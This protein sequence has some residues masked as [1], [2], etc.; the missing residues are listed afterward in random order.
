M[1]RDY[2]ELVC[3]IRTAVRERF[4]DPNQGAFRSYLE[5][6]HVC[7]LGNAF[8]IISGSAEDVKEQI[9]EK[10]AGEVWQKS[11]LAMRGFVYDAL[12]EIGLKEGDMIR[13]GDYELQYYE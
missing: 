10:L 1:E 9:A 13:I 12:L 7:D 4:Y 2:S 6:E 5:E 11:A 3:K 8:A